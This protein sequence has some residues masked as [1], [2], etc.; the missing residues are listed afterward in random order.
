MHAFNESIRKLGL[1]ELPLSGQQFTW[2]NSQQ[3]PLLERLDWVFVSQSWSTKYLA[4]WV[5]TLPRDTPDHV[6]YVV[7]F[8]TSVPKARIFRFEIFWLQHG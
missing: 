1:I 3:H 2:I 5:K 4:S 6:P 8:K 7:S